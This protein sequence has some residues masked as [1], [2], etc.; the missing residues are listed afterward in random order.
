MLSR[1][2]NLVFVI[3][4]VAVIGLLGWLSEQHSVE[5]DLTWG[6]RNSLT[7]ASVN[8]LQALDKPVRITAF[9]RDG[10]KAVQDIIKDL[11]ERYQRHKPDI[12]ISFLNPDLVPQL[13]REH[14]IT[15]DGEIL[16]QYGLRQET[17]QSPSEKSLTQLL[18]K[19]AGS[20]NSFVT[21]ISGHGERN[22]LGMA[23]HDLGEFG[24]QLEKRGFILQELNLV[25][26]PGIPSNTRVLVIGSAKTPYLEGEYKLIEDFLA[27]GGNLL[28]LTE[29]GADD[30]LNALAALLDI[31]RLPGQ[32]VDAT[33]RLFGINDPTFALAVD[34][35]RHAI[36][37]TLHSQTLFPQAT[38]FVV[39]DESDWQAAAILQTL[40]RSWTELDDIEG[41]IRFDEDTQE[42]PGPITI[43]MA[44]ERQLENIDDNSSI[45]QRVVVIGDGDFLSN[46]YLGNGQNLDLGTAVFQ[47][48]N[49]SDNL[50]DIGSV[51]APDTQLSVT[52]SGAIALLLAFLVI[53]PL[54]LLGTGITIWFKR[55][56]R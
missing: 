30:E 15:V 4:F 13:V 7:E 17:L 45:T 48:L 10:N 19:L 46:A 38:G 26:T 14:G 1:L 12:D 25:K 11:V 29:P 23:N 37:E 5:V 56:R 54:G 52:R 42:R 8:A 28:W 50:I 47:W 39:A 33:S 24:Q 31:Q 35:P 6:N 41:D 21:F 34:Y 3:L 44:L 9:V 40:P 2:Q 53:L 16:V 20:D 55:R 27:Q 49:H 36:S 22:L 32:V 18:V 43:G 51:S